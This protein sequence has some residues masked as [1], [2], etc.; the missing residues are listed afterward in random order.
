MFTF[1]DDPEDYRYEN[2]KQFDAMFMNNGTHIQQNIKDPEIRESIIRFVKEGGGFMGIHAAADGGWDD[3]NHMIGHRFNGHPWNAGDEHAFVVEEPDHCLACGFDH[4]QFRLQDE[5]YVAR[6][7]YFTRDDVRVIINMDLSDSLTASRPTGK[8][9]RSDK[10]YSVTQVRQ[11]GEGLVYYTSFGHN[12]AV[13]R[14]PRVLKHYLAGLQYVTGD[15]DAPDE[16][17]GLYERLKRIDGPVQHEAKLK[18]LQKARGHDSMD[19]AVALAGRLIQD[20]QASFQS[21]VTALEAL[22]AAPSMDAYRAALPAL[23]SPDQ[24]ANVVRFYTQNMDAATYS[25]MVSSSWPNLP[26]ESQLEVISGMAHYGEA[27]SAELLKL[28]K[29]ADAAIQMHALWALGHSKSSVSVEELWMLTGSPELMIVRDELIVALLKEQGTQVASQ[30]FKRIL[31]ESENNQIRF[32]AAMALLAMDSGASGSLLQSF[33]SATDP[34]LVEA[35]IASAKQ[36]THADAAEI[37]AEAIPNLNTTQARNALYALGAQEGSGVAGIVERFYASEALVLDAVGIVGHIGSAQ[38]VEPLVRLLGN[39]DKA[40]SSAASNALGLL[41]GSA[42]DAEVSRFLLTADAKTQLAL[43]KV[44]SERGTLSMGAAALKLLDSPDSKVARQA[45][46][47]LALAGGP[48]EFEALALRVAQDPKARSM[49]S[50][51]SKLGSRISDVSASSKVLIDADRQA[52]AK[53]RPIIVALLGEL[54]S[55]EGLRYLQ[56]LSR[57]EHADIEFSAVK[58]LANWEGTQPLQSLVNTVSGTADARTR[59]TALKGAVHMLAD[60][61]D[62][63]ARE[64][65]EMTQSLLKYAMEPKDIQACLQAIATL[66]NS[67]VRELS[68]EYLAHADASVVATARATINRSYQAASQV[69]WTF[70]SNFNNNERE[71]LRMIDKDPKTRWSSLAQMKHASDMWVTV[72][73]GVSQSVD[74]ISI[75]TRASAGD[76]P[77]LFEVYVSDDPDSWGEPALD[78]RG[79]T[80]IDANL[81][82]RGRYVKIVQKGR[83]GGYWS[84]H[85]LQINGMPGDQSKGLPLDLTSADIQSE[86]N[87]EKVSLIKDGNPRTGWQTPRNQE[88]GNA[89]IIDLGKTNTLSFLEI[90]RENTP[91]DKWAETLNIYT[92]DDINSFGEPIAVLKNNPE[93]K[94]Q[95]VALY[96][97]PVRYVKLEIAENVGRKWELSELKLYHLQ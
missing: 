64:K 28:A 37:L 30:G 58:A 75:D 59:S 82:A 41:R 53:N 81:Q 26:V 8:K 84:I 70:E 63:S 35:A 20:P 72:D 69:N 93:E 85:E 71:L 94:R 62:F 68:K 57:D 87:P 56:N 48:A 3:Y 80:W 66:P 61:D 96:P 14:D 6:D 46:R 39:A 12:E 9:Q 23:A 24:A 76:Y 50:S 83:E 54:Q 21:K 1:T 44:A 10:D 27:F 13:Y 97:F 22:S 29:S 36:N 86:L 34:V 90:D 89:L 11:F 67:E 25:D 92:A 65:V 73:L 49:K 95:S 38:Q 91:K 79:S 17:V 60:A 88:S 77:R 4:Q 33:L 47:T 43:L 5:I 74:S 45:M 32:A 2:L 16:P 42:V 18:L 19:E 40:I 15:L 55:P 7:P 78:G 52:L 51:L 31:K